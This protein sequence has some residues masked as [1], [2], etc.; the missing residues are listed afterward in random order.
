MLEF[1]EKWVGVKCFWLLAT[2][3]PQVTLWGRKDGLTPEQAKLVYCRLAYP[4]NRY[5]T[6]D[7]VAARL[8]TQLSRGREGV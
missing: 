6:G 8:I 4:T 3:D 1:L 7:M 5:P 2:D